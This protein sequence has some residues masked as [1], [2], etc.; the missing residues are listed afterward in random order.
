[1]ALGVEHVDRIVLDPIEQQAKPLLTIMQRR[2][3]LLAFGDIRPDSHVLSRLTLPAHEGNNGCI[4][5]VNR[6]VFSPVLDLAVPDFAV[7]DACVHLLEEF[8]RMVAGVEDA[9][10]LPN[11]LIFGKF[12]DT[13]E[14]VVDIGDRAPDVGYG[15]D[16]MLV[17]RELLV[18]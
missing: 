17:E 8:F 6:A 5:P 18:G 7:G 2:F 12:A 1:M 4:N 13:A 9:V 3:C 15:H 10:V 11:Q 14:L 16:G